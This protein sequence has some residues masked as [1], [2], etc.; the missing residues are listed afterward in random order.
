MIR[1]QIKHL[2]CT[3]EVLFPVVHVLP[4]LLPLQPLALPD[5]EVRIL[6]LQWRER[7]ALSLGKGLVQGTELLEEHSHGPGIGNNVVHRQQKNV[8]ALTEPQKRSPH[9]GSLAQIEGSLRVFQ[10]Q[11]F[12]LA[13][14]LDRRQVAEI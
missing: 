3:L 10:G 14:P 8:F 4:E 2:R 13:G 11:A 9:Q 5:R 1:W 6:H 12:E 7:R